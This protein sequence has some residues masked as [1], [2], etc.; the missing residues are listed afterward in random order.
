MQRF[1]IINDIGPLEKG[2][3]LLRYVKYAFM[4]GG[5]IMAYLQSML[6][7]VLIAIMVWL[8]GGLAEHFGLYGS[9]VLVHLIGLAGVAVWL[10]IIR[11]ETLQ[12]PK[13]LPP[14][15]FMGGIIGALTVVFNNIGFSANG[16]SITLALGL[17]GQM[18]FSVM[19]DHFGLLG[20]SK[21]PIQRRQLLSLSLVTVGIIML[22]V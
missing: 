16:V 2:K 20:V 22:A 15:L 1:V 3:K 6:I 4:F 21:R 10:F 14:Y 11:K 17:L 7:G 9:T 18:C 13:N 8:N 5:L 12:L 19:V